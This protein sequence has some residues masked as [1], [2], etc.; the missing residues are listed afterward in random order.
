MLEILDAAAV[1][2]WSHASLA[3][4]ARARDE[5]DAINVYPVAD[6][7]TGTNLLLT[8]EAAAEAVTAAPGDDLRGALQALADGALIGA[9]GNSGVIVSQLL[10]GLAAVLGAA[11]RPDGRALASALATATELG[12]QAVG[13]P[14]EGTILTV[15]RAAADAATASGSSV[16]AAVSSAAARGAQTALAATT[17]QLEVLRRAG[18]VDAGGRGLCVLLDALAEVVTEITPSHHP[19]TR[20]TVRPRTATAV[21]DDG[22]AYEV[23]YLLDAA[24]DA[25]PPLRERLSTVGDAVV[26]VGGERLW[27]VHVHLDDPGAAVEAGIAAGRPYRIKITDL[28]LAHAPN[29][30]N[31][32]DEDGVGQQLDQ[33]RR[34]VVATASAPGI[35]ELL[36]QAGVVVVHHEPGHPPSSHAW[37]EAMTATSADEIVLVVDGLEA[38]P[39]AEAAARNARADGSRVAVIPARS[40]VQTIAAIA[41]HDPAH[42]FDADVIAMSAAGGSARHA[43][44]TV[45][46]AEAVTSAGLCKPGDMLGHIGDDIAVIGEDVA[47]VAQAVIARMLDA[48][49]E[50]ITLIIGADAP[51]GLAAELV[52]RLRRTRPEIECTAYGGGQRDCLLLIGVE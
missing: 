4:L 43:Q 21:A 23:M 5:I 26:V 13:R 36:S 3:G 19:T 45:A 34:V 40:C 44:V 32:L 22:S 50:L 10:R 52:D 41:V 42:D 1:R 46:T 38:R 15:A 17:A 9:R 2:R 16:L 47:Q 7:D 24:E 35:A 51:P 48:G 25:I 31:D 30:S 39:I 8:M 6:S 28:R 33:R 37:R 14:V 12:Y 18:V 29:R 11:K 49:G 27:N 20:V